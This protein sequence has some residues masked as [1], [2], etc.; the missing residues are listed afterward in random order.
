M[1]QHVNWPHREIPD[2]PHLAWASFSLPTDSG[3][4][5]TEVPLGVR[6]PTFSRRARTGRE[7]V[8]TTRCGHSDRQKRSFKSL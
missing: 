7:M 3:H 1:P 2:R 5:D 4:S 6:L 8:D